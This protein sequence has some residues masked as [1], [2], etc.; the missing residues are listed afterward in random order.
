MMGSVITAAQTLAA[1]RQAQADGSLRQLCEDHG[2]EVLVLF[3]SAIQRDDFHDVDVAVGFSDPAASDFLD[4]V[5]ALIALIPGDHLDVM[6][7][8]RADPLA[9]HRAL[10]RCEVLFATTPSAFWERQ[11]GAIGVYWD[12]QFMRDLELELLRNG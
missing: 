5:N 9:R 4:F 6:P 3:G 2:A 11:I 1:L 12:T 7:L 10:T 8:D